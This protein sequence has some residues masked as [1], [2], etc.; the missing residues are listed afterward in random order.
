MTAAHD[1]CVPVAVVLRTIVPAA[2]A[3]GINLE[4]IA[5][6][7]G[8]P[9]SA[10]S[11]ALLDFV[12]TCAG[13]AA[14][15]GL[16][17]LKQTGLLHDAFQ[18]ALHE[19]GLALVDAGL[20]LALLLTTH[21]DTAALQNAKKS[22]FLTSSVMNS[23]QQ[24]IEAYVDKRKLVKH[25]QLSNTIQDMIV[26]PSK[27]GI[28]LNPDN[29]EFAYLPVVASG[30]DFNL[31][32]GAESDDRKL[33]HGVMLIH[34]GSKYLGRCSNICRTLFVN[35]SSQCAPAIPVFLQLIGCTGTPPPAVHLLL[36]H[37]FCHPDKEP[38]RLQDSTAAHFVISGLVALLVEDDS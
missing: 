2:A 24:L 27:S 22:G 35:P 1:R 26:N 5:V 34:F 21:D 19:S 30:G 6:P 28:K 17:K 38:A 8:T 4:I 3:A 31:R 36:M 14:V 7:K 23:T 33:H 25:S 32:V 15:G 37:E 16:T 13:D 10:E 12:R 11:R 20:A 9:G 18:T 29:C